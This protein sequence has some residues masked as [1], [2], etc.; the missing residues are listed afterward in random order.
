MRATEIRNLNEAEVARKLD[1]AHQE[2]FNLRFQY[3]TGQLKNTTRL[4]LVKREIARLRT[5]L[6]E[7]ELAAAQGE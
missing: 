7:R 6:R 1:E 2:L 4:S 3:S 5:I